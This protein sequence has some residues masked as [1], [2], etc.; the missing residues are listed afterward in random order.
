M[1]AATL[2]TVAAAAGSGCASTFTPVSPNSDVV[3][4]G[5][6]VELPDEWP[7]DFPVTEDSL[8][9][10]SAQ[11]EGTMSIIMRA[12]ETYE[13][14]VEFYDGA[15][16]GA[17]AVSSRESGNNATRWQLESGGLVEVINGDPTEIGVELPSPS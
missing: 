9:L 1:L 17:Y 11:P 12:P 13:E 5:E 10:V 7:E 8:L 6:G 2:V 16:T 15:L 3:D 4:Y 14:V